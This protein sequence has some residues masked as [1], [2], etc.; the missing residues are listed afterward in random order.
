MKN[1]IT[2]L[3][4]VFGFSLF[5]QQIEKANRLAK[6]FD[7][8]ET[9]LVLKKIIKK[10]YKGKNEAIIKLADTYRIMNYPDSAC[11]WYSIS[12]SLDSVNPIT[13]YYYG[14]SLRSLGKYDD[15]KE[16]FLIYDSLTDDPRGK[17]YA[18]YCDEIKSFIGVNYYNVKNVS[19]LNSDKSDF[20]PVVFKNGIVLSSDRYVKKNGDIYEWTGNPYL[21]LFYFEPDS[22]G[23]YNYKI[24]SKNIHSEYHDATPTFNSKGDIVY[25]TRTVRKNVDKDSDNMKTNKLMIFRSDYNYKN[26]KW[27]KPVP[28]TLNNE[29]Y[30]IGHPFLLNDT[31]MYFVSDMDG[32]YGGTDIYVSY[33]GDSGWSDP[34]NLGSEINTFGNEMFPSVDNGILYFSSDGHLGYGGLD[35]F[36]ASYKDGTWLVENLKQPINS[37]YDDFGLYSGMF[38]SNRPGGLGEDDVYSFVPINTMICGRV[39]DT[40]GNSVIGVTIFFYMESSDVYEVLKTDDFGLYCKKDIEQN[41]NYYIKA[42][43]SGYFD[44]CGMMYIGVQYKSQTI[45][46]PDIVLSKMETQK[47]YVINNIYYDFDKWDIREDSKKSLDSIVELMNKY[48]IKIELGSH[49][50]SRGSSEY[51]MELSQKRAESAV[52]YIVSKGISRNRITAIG[53]GESVMV[54]GCVDGVYCSDKQHQENRRTEFKIIDIPIETSIIDNIY[55]G[56]DVINI[57]DFN[58]DFLNCDKK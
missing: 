10:D 11:K 27:E 26:K 29:K 24:F 53:Y 5:G 20:T 52:D 46:I 21:T 38:S 25:F 50:D 23:N 22:N 55:K 54:N 17:I 2:L 35:I 51:N 33:L 41:S 1:L 6:Y 4:I 48:D 9:I 58:D 12:V 47:E 37:S 13:Y 14:Q 49:T 57:T 32:G 19:D 43:K 45:T 42:L 3:L 18:N 16:Q 39:V 40:Q 36:E 34:V 28:I 15:A 8:S 7:Y 44:N 56:G 30:S 31:I